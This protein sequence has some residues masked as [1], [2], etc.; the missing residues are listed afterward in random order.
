MSNK[1]GFQ[2]RAPG[3]IHGQQLRLVACI[4]TYGEVM[5]RRGEISR[6]Y[7]SGMAGVRMGMGMGG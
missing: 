2:N 4:Q 5:G 1:V 7:R 3:Q 6:G